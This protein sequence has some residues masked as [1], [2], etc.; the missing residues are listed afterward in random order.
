MNSKSG[1]MYMAAMC[2]LFIVAPGRF[3]SGLVLIIGLALFTVTG[4]LFCHFLKFLKMNEMKSV[5]LIGFIVFM[6]MLYRQILILTMPSLALSMSFILFL[7]AISTYVISFMFTPEENSLSV[8]LKKNALHIAKVS[9][10]GFFVSLVRDVFGYGTFTFISF[11][12]VIE[13]VIFPEEKISLMSFIASIPGGFI[14]SALILVVYMLILK[15]I[16][17]MKRAGL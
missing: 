12:G 9:L 16:D 14:L 2:S 17:V 13:K 5:L 15:K 1:Y 11:N 6:V 3:A 7:A 4:T 8:D 10:Y